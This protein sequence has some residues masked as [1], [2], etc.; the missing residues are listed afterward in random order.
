MSVKAHLEQLGFNNFEQALSQLAH[1]FK[2]ILENAESLSKNGIH[3]LSSHINLETPSKFIS[4]SIIIDIGGS[5]TKVALR[6][7]DELDSIINWILLFE[8]PNQAFKSAGSHGFASY[9]TELARRIV[10]AL[11]KRIMSHADV[12]ALGVVWSNA[13]ESKLVPAVGVTGLVTRR[14]EYRKAEWFLEDL[15]DGDD[16]G[17]I[18]IDA[19]ST[20]GIK[21][22]KLIVSND[23][24]LTL[25]ALPHANAGVVASTGLNGTLIQTQKENGS[26]TKKVICNPELGY[27]LRIE[28]SYLCEADMIAEFIEADRIEY[29]VGGK[30]LPKLFASY[31][32]GLATIGF[33]PLHHLAERLKALGES[34]FE[35]FSSSDL[36]ALIYNQASFVQTHA[37]LEPFSSETLSALAEL[38]SELILRAAR[39]AGLTCYASISN[40]LE[41]RSVFTVSLDS[42]LAREIPIFWEV[43]QTSLVSLVAPPKTVKLALLQPQKA[44]GGS[45]SVPMLGA[46]AALDSI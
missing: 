15:K 18:L 31:V 1:K 37:K 30:F 44:D 32:C 24:C 5:S 41:D 12:K 20:H 38:A 4:K 26:S 46:A 34:R 23:A 29:L 7:H 17:R 16:I 9:C 13:L 25:K 27:N 35:Y 2:G 36:Y 19:F 42:R 40:Q 45:V 8:E 28:T 22:G 6:V 14:N 3:A 33:K 39:L 43:L 11:T 10:E 21:I